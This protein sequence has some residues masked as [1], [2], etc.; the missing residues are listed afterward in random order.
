MKQSTPAPTLA[1]HQVGVARI[2]EM[3]SGASSHAESSANPA[4]AHASSIRCASEFH[5]C[6]P[7]KMVEVTTPAMVM[8][9]EAPEPKGHTY[10]GR[11][12]CAWRAASPAQRALSA[13]VQANGAHNH[14][15]VGI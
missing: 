10:R 1:R 2:F 15:R 6:R 11:C 9:A 5:L 14:R 3:P 8:E 13:A 7:R 12:K 4:K